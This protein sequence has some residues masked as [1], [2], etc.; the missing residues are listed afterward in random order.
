VASDWGDSTFDPVGY[1]EAKWQTR[2]DGTSAGRGNFSCYSNPTVDELIEAGA[3]EPDLQKRRKIYGETQRLI[4]QD[5][6]AIFLYVP[7]EVEAASANVRNWQPS[8]DSRINL[9]DVWLAGE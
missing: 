2:A 8:P 3:S 6:P 5:A 9:H 7:Q 4:Y 1:I